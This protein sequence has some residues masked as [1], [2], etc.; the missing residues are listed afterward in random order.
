MALGKFFKWIKNSASKVKD[1]VVKAF[2]KTKDFI[3]SGGAQ[4]A[5]DAVSQGLN[6]AG[7]VIQQLPQNNKFVQNAS[8]VIQGA[9]GVTNKAQNILGQIPVVN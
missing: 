8:N 6:V 3:S 4:R 7:N 2:N 9:R 5:M 1:G